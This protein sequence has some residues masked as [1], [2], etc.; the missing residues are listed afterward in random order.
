MAALSV[1]RR[2]CARQRETAALIS[3]NRRWYM[4][5]K[6]TKSTCPATVFFFPRRAG[7]AVVMYG[8]KKKPITTSVFHAYIL[9]RTA[10]S[11]QEL[12]LPAT[13]SAFYFCRQDIA[14]IVHLHS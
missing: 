3:Q 1:G 6:R 13:L 2:S 7:Q 4:Q 5:S 14:A 8:D 11:F 9:G 12:Y 10:G